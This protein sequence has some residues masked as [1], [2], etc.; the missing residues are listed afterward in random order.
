MRRLLGLLLLCRTFAVHGQTDAVAIRHARIGELYEAQRFAELIREIEVQLEAV[1]GTTYADSLH[2]YL[3]KY[4]RAYRKVKDAPASTAAAERIYALVKARKNAQHELEAL[5]DLSWIYYDVGEIKQCARVDSLAVRVADSDPSVPISQRGRARQYLAFDHSVIGD[6]RRSSQWALAAIEQYGKADSIPEAQWAES[7]TA[8]GVAAWHLGRI[9]EAEGYYGQALEKLGDGTSE[10]IL[11]RKATAYGNLGILWQSAGDVVRAQ[12]YYHENLRLYERLLE[13]T[14]DQFTRDEVILNRSR[15]YVNLATVYYE[16]GDHG[17]AREFL[18]MAWRDRSQV[19]EAD[20]AQLLSLK[21][22][23]ADLEINAGHPDKARPLLETYVHAS[24]LRFGR[25]SEEYVRAT[26]KLADAYAQLGDFGKADSLFGIS[27]EAAQRGRDAGTD[28]MLAYAL[29]LRGMARLRA[30][31][32]DEAQQDYL[33]AREVLVQTHDSMHHKVAQIDG[34]CAEAAF[35]SGDIPAA[36]SHAEKALRALDERIVSLRKSPLPTTYPEP[37]VVPDA[38]YW[39]VR[40]ESVLAGSRTTPAQWRAWN[41]DIDLAITALARNKADLD[42][43]ASK[44]LL[45]GAQRRLFDLALDLAY[46]SRGAVGM[47]AACE[48]FLAVSEADRAILLKEH[49]NG[50]K[51]LRFSGVPDSI[52]AREQELLQALTIDP[53]DPSS[54]AELHTHELN[55]LAFLERLRTEHPT[56]FALRHGEASTSLADMRKYLLKPGRTVVSYAQS[57]S[58]WYGLVVTDSHA[59]LVELDAEGLAERVAALNAAIAARDNVRYRA[60][61]FRLHQQLVEP[62]LP[63]VRGNELLI[64]PDGPLRLVN[65]EV[66]HTQDP[67]ISKRTSS[68]LLHRY[69]IAYLLSATTA[70]QFA[71]LARERSHRTLALAPGFT[72]EV[73]QRYLANTADTSRIDRDYLRYVRQPF[74]LRAAEE[75]GRTF[76]ASVLLGSNATERAFRNGLRDHGILHLGTH[77]EMNATDPMYSRL[78]LNKDASSHATGGDV[79]DADGYLHAYEIY[80]LDL[81]AQLAVLAACGTGTG[82]DDGEGVRS[83]GYSF[84]YA[85]CPSLVMSLWSIDEKTSSAIITRF[86]EL[87]AD[88]LPKHEALRQAK[89]DHLATADEELALPYY[90]AGLVLVGDV[91]PIEVDAWIRYKWWVFGACILLVLAL[92]VRR[93]Q[94]VAR[95]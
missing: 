7:Y 31:R 47:E 16:R 30:G 64:I 12:Y 57:A 54:A 37:H 58:T 85:G 79:P 2:R 94:R 28:V 23:Y 10:A 36:R 56:Y 26:A 69:T 90:W 46:A 77:A 19:L 13:Q 95:S 40:A 21:E 8:A 4:G 91:E 42:D 76:N 24:E 71:E 63:H 66:L 25:H 5:F 39:K 45:T 32:P 89:L 3:Y 84:A 72:D 14:A 55:Y 44:L 27:L 50:F 78:V 62:L 82:I 20:D 43:A 67:S 35:T 34:L 93:W 61:A 18:D 60:V 92:V 6:H 75:L 11:N 65:F 81:R 70:V 33:R 87:L 59:E 86:Y 29:K 51:G 22:R 68:L 49:L 17:R 15:T 48:R 53:E 1:K 83:L 88:G 73:K 41:T 38:I 74:A 80:E 9:R 52:I